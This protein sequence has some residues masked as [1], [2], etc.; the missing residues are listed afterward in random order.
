M[1]YIVAT[2]NVTTPVRVHQRVVTMGKSQSINKTMNIIAKHC[3]GVT[4]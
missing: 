2:R 4:S 1:L 3:D